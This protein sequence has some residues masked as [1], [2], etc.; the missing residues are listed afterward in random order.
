[1]TL[2]IKKAVKVHENG[3]RCLALTNN[4]YG[5]SPILLSSCLHNLP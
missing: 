5:H 4:V 2:K 1:M 3:V